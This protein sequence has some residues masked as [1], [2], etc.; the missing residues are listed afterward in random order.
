MD[1]IVQDF[2]VA[3]DAFGVPYELIVV[4]NGNTDLSTDSEETRNGNVL[5]CTLKAAG[6]G[7]AVVHGCNRAQGTFVCY[8]NS[9]R[10]QSE[11]LI[12]LARYALLSED[13]I[14]KATRIDRSTWMR[15]WVSIMY[16]L[17][18]RIILG[19]PIWDVNATPKIVPKKLLLSLPLKQLNDSIDAELMYKAF[20]KNIPIIEIPMRQIERRGG[21]STTN[22]QSALSMFLGLWCIRLDA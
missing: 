14:V 8:T 1:A 10:T 13:T 19:T 4:I 9:A 5:S 11:E 20:K 15:K 22:W 12:R 3:L 2:K 21:S 17:L 16:N 6:W 18:N 7:R